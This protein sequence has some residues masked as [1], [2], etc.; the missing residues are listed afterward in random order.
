MRRRPVAVRNTP[1]ATAMMPTPPSSN[2]HV[3]RAAC[4]ALI[5]V[6]VDP[7]KMGSVVAVPAGACN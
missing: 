7:W 2:F 6:G 4:S 1:P 5:V 3:L